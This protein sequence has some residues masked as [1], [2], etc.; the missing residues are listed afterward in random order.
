MTFTFTWLAECGQ[1]KVYKLLIQ[2]QAL[3]VLKM[4][5]KI[6]YYIYIVYGGYSFLYFKRLWIQ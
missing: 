6:I 5:K 2:S 3:E 4:K 1:S